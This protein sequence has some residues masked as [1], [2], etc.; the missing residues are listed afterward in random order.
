MY[1]GTG[2]I[3]VTQGRQHSCSN[4]TYI[5]IGGGEIKQIRT[6]ANGEHYAENWNKMPQE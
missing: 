5:I 3:T 2:T 4:R 1:I 6:A